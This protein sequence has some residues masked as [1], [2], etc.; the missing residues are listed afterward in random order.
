M[1]KRGI[2]LFWKLQLPRIKKF[3]WKLLNH[4]LAERAFLKRRILGIEVI[5]PLC[6]QEKETDIHMFWNC[7]YSRTIWLEVELWW[8]IK[9]TVSSRKLHS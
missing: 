3:I 7:H 4:I 9:I 1:L 8:N 5:C 6:H 2:P